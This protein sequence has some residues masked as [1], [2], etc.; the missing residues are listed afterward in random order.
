MNIQAVPTIFYDL[1]RILGKCARVDCFFDD[2]RLS[3]PQKF[4]G[5]QLEIHSIVKSSSI[6]VRI[7]RSRVLILS[8]SREEDKKLLVKESIPEKEYRFFL[9][10]EK[11]IKAGTVFRVQNGDWKKYPPSRVMRS[12]R[13][14][15]EL[16]DLKEFI[17][18][19]YEIR[20]WGQA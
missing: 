12:Q 10:Q 1:K 15:N 6:F 19:D 17:S 8:K 13:I 9:R 2:K 5:K 18:G 4:R 14:Q 20:S 16:K 11:G 7:S 3:V